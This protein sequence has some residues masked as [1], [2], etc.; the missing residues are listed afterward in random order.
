MCL[1][2]YLSMW[3][4]ARLLLL[5]WKVA[6]LPQQRHLRLLPRRRR[7]RLGRFASRDDLFVVGLNDLREKRANG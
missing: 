3:Y 6:P 5:G 2:E 4:S 1:N 7:R